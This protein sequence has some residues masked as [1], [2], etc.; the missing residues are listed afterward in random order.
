MALP[1]V[2]PHFPYATFDGRRDEWPV[3]SPRP[4][5]SLN[6][7]AETPECGLLSVPGPS[8]M[9]TEGYARLCHTEE[10]GVSPLKTIKKNLNHSDFFAG[11]SALYY[12]HKAFKGISTLL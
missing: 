1:F 3:A 2:T 4:P 8:T 10:I 6:E 12:V 5:A 11:L 7:S 9:S